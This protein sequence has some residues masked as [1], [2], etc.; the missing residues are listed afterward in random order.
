MRRMYTDAILP[1]FGSEEGRVRR[2]KESLDQDSEKNR[3]PQMR[4]NAGVTPFIAPVCS[5]S[6]AEHVVPRLRAF[7][8][9]KPAVDWVKRS[10][11]K[12]EKASLG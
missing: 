3:I 8:Q 5:R 6:S 2:S 4:E 9:Q 1:E 7:I 12:N 10:W 11:E